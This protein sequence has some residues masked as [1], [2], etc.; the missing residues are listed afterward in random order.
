MSDPS[1]QAIKLAASCSLT[2]K[3]T[4]WGPVPLWSANLVAALN[5]E[6]DFYAADEATAREILPP[7]AQDQIDR[8]NG[9]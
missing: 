4:D 5:A 6:I 7:L 3:G 2:N 9:S 1:P 8:N